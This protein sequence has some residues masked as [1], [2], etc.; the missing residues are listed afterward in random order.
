RKTSAVKAAEDASQAPPATLTP[1]E[2]ALK[3]S[4]ASVAPLERPRA[5]DAEHMPPPPTIPGARICRAER[6]THVVEQTHSSEDEGASE[7]NDSPRDD[8]HSVQ[9]NN[10]IKDNNEVD[11]NTSNEATDKIE[12]AEARANAHDDNI[13]EASDENRCENDPTHLRTARTHS[14]VVST[15]VISTPVVSTSAVST[16][17]VSTPAVS[18]PAVSTPAISTPAIST[19]VISTPVSAPTVSAPVVSAPAVSAPAPAV[20]APAVSAPVMGS[21]PLHGS[22]HTTGGFIRGRAHGN[23]LNHADFCYA[24]DGYALVKPLLQFKI[25]VHVESGDV[26][27]LNKVPDFD[28]QLPVAVFLLSG[29]SLLAKPLLERASQLHTSINNSDVFFHS[30]FS[31]RWLWNLQGQYSFVLE[32]NEEVPHQTGDQGGLECHILFLLPIIQSSRVFN[33][34][35]AGPLTSHSRYTPS[36]TDSYP[37]NMSSE[38]SSSKSRRLDQKLITLL[39]DN[40]IEFDHDLCQNIDKPSLQIIYQRYC[41]VNEINCQIDY[42]KK[43][44][45]WIGFTPTKTDITNLFVAKTT[46]HSSYATR[47][48]AAEKHEDMRAWLAEE[49]GCVSEEELWG[50]VKNN[51]TMKDLEEWLEKKDGKKVKVVKKGEAKYIVKGKEKKEGSK[52][53]KNKKKS[54]GIN[55]SISTSCQVYLGFSIVWKMIVSMPLFGILMVFLFFCPGVHAA[56]PESAFPN[57]SFEI[58]STFIESTFGPKISLSTV[59]MLLFT[60]NENTDLLNLHARSQNPQFN[61]EQ[62]CSSSTWMNALSHAIQQN[63]IEKKLKSLFKQNEMP[64]DL[65]GSEARELMSIKLDSF[66]NLLGLNPFGPNGQPIKR[67]STLIKGTKIFKNVS[68]MS[69]YCPKCNTSYFVDHEAYGPSH[70]R[71]RT[72]LNDA[73]YIKI[74]Q[75]TYVDR[76][77]STAVINGT[78]S[79]HASTA[80]YAEFWTNSFGKTHAV[81]VPRRQIWQA[82]IQESICSVSHTLGITFETNDNLAIAELTNKAFSLLGENGGI[83]LSNGHACSE[84]TQDYKTTAD[85]TPL[86]NDPAAVLGVDDNRLVPALA[87]EN[88]VNLN[89][90]NQP[91]NVASTVTNSPVKMIVMDGIVMGPVHCAADNCTADLLNARGEAFCATHVTEFANRCRVVGCRNVKVQGTQACPQHQQDWSHHRQL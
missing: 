19:L 38:L 81:K 80:A 47:I 53:M 66:Q 74:G 67:L 54:A 2:R 52:A 73:C 7:D 15:P 6:L 32:T 22:S 59:L 61:Y 43:E 82:F 85:Y 56:G 28:S 71:K 57:I 91:I 64:D 70:Q 75:S 3:A 16:P 86:N 78:Y 62:K 8:N 65:T 60:L 49:V 48:P 87:D 89:V 77:F 44:R 76:I 72:Y 9:D 13:E 5:P 21:P 45:T 84:C 29:T 4:G 42:M 23:A 30:D 24:D 37:D 27:G 31:G 83:R 41:A 40:G 25:Y 18:T 33:P 34:V 69:A 90:P 79:F 26:L 14:P 35:L 39:T 46:W 55:T 51:Y 11:E 50:E 10:S 20:S 68:V 12:E 1:A 88:P 17:A 58:F 63:T 36:N